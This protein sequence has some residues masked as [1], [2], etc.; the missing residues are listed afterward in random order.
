MFLHLW[1]G[2]HFIGT[3]YTALRFISQCL[4]FLFGSV[5]HLYALFHVLACSK[6]DL[7]NSYT[8]ILTA[9]ACSKQI[10]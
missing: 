6:L 9:K 2:K 10:L 1:H 5:F 4:I 7:Y 8:I 3:L